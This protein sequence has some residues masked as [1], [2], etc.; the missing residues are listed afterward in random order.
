MSFRKIFEKLNIFSQCKKYR[1]PLWQCPDFLFFIMGLIIICL[2]FVAYA[3]SLQYIEDPRFVSLIVLFIASILLIIA[4]IINRSFERLVEVN[5]IKSE[6]ISIASHQLQ[7][8]ISNLKWSLEFLMS[9]RLGE[10]DSRQFEYLKILKENSE[11]ME[12]LIKDLLIVSKIESEEFSQKKE[13]FSLPDLTLE[14]IKKFFPFA[15]LAKV[16]INYYF[17]EKTPLVFADRYQIQQVIENLLDNAIRYTK[18]GSIDV[19]IEK[20]DKKIYFEIR[21]TGIGIPQEEQKYVFQ[22]FFRAKNIMKYQTLGTGLGLYIS[23][24]IIERSG[25]KIGFKSQEGKGSTF[26]FILPTK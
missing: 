14:V 11:R 6:F 3:L 16:Q 5:R 18:E 13:E 26:W 1:I 2:I 12:E 9:G 21:D 23:K 22:K 25:G 7:A 8:P 15:K 19:R 4:F 20:K 17:E 24:A 10:I